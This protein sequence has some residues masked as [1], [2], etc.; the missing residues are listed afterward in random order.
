VTVADRVLVT[1]RPAVVR[2]GRVGQRPIGILRQ[3]A[4]RRCRVRTDGQD[5]AVGIGVVAQNAGG[6]H[7]QHRVLIGAVSIIMA[8]G[9]SLALFMV[10]VTVAVSVPP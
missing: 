8:T 4:M 6:R 7:G 2:V 1:V 5:I 3:I 9:S 10:T